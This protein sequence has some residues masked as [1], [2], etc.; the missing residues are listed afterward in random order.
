MKISGVR[1]LNLQIFCKVLLAYIGDKLLRSSIID[2]QKEIIAYFNALIRLDLYHKA[3][4]KTHYIAESRQYGQF[5]LRKPFSSDYKVFEQ[6]FVV[7]EYLLLAELIERHC[8]NN[9]VFFID[10]GANVG[11]ATIFV[12]HYLKGKKKIKAILIEPFKDNI[13][14]ARLNFQL[15]NIDNV[16]FEMAGLY[17]KSC[18]LRID[19]GFRDGMEWS[20]QTTECNEPTELKAIQIKD[21]SEKYSLERIDVLKLDI[22]GAEKFLFE[23]ENYASSFLKNVSIISI[24]LHDEY[25]IASKILHTLE[26]NQFKLQKYGELHVGIKQH[27]LE[28]Q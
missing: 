24:E 10:G 20:I 11:F 18:Y 28:K 12:Q 19:H 25:N 15:R 14:T 23:D 21:L 16:Y 13:E 26:K 22:E 9:E 3:D 27:L 8:Q 5:Y 7:K 17:N 4:A 2:G 6:I 1:R